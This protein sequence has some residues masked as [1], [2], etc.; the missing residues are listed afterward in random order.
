MDVD[1]INIKFRYQKIGNQ[2]EKRTRLVYNLIVDSSEN[3]DHM[4]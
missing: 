1:K 2:F 4:Y 3:K